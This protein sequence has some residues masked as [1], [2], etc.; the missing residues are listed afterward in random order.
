MLTSG[1]PVGLSASSLLKLECFE[2]GAADTQLTEL[3]QV[4]HLHE[5]WAWCAEPGPERPDVLQLPDPLALL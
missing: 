2:L 3:G 4:V 1:Q 5:R